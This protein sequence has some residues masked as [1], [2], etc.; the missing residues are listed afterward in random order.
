MSSLQDYAAQWQ[1]TVPG[2][3]GG[4]AAAVLGLGVLGMT[5]LEGAAQPAVSAL[6]WAYVAHIIRIPAVSPC[7]MPSLL[8]T[9]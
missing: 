3:V 2:G 4:V 7:L 5:Q 8:L 9:P 1:E 6:D